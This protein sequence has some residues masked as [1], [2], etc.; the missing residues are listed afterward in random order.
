MHCSVNLEFYFCLWGNQTRMTEGQSKRSQLWETDDHSEHFRTDL[1]LCFCFSLSSSV[2]ECLLVWECQVTP[3]SWFSLHP[4]WESAKAHCSP[5]SHLLLRHRCRCGCPLFLRILSECQ[6]CFS[7]SVFRFR[8]WVGR[9]FALL[10]RCWLRSLSIWNSV[11]F[12]LRFVWDFCW[13]SHRSSLWRMLCCALL[14]FLLFSD[15]FSFAFRKRYSFLRSQRF[16]FQRFHSKSFPE[17]LTKRNL[18]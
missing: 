9:N 15:S 12:P 17:N 13:Q 10:L 14:R 3:A 2:F 5:R 16:R 18:I 8:L 7:F 6:I 1:H 11:C 4:R